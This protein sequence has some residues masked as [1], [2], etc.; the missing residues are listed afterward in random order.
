MCKTKI[1]KNRLKPQ[2][3]SE[4]IPTRGHLKRP[5]PSFLVVYKTIWQP[6]RLYRTDWLYESQ[7]EFSNS[8]CVCINLNFF[9]LKNNFR[10]TMNPHQ[11][12]GRAVMEEPLKLLEIDEN[13]GRLSLIK[14]NTNV[15][16]NE[17]RPVTVVAGIGKLRMGKSYLLRWLINASSTSGKSQFPSI[18]AR[19]GSRSSIK[20]FCKMMGY[21]LI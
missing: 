4:N 17:D 13:S 18:C 10:E 7:T 14:A 2:N 11:L 20:S 12:S 21:T 1:S 16:E 9:E 6:C 15:L 3:Q 8:I 19:M 5:D